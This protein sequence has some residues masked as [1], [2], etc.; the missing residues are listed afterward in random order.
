MKA[1]DIIPQAAIAALLTIFMLVLVEIYTMMSANQANADLNTLMLIM[2]GMVGFAFVAGGFAAAYL[3]ARNQKD[4]MDRAL[5]SSSM[6]GIIT[7]LV[8]GLL[9]TA[10]LVASGGDTGE[11]LLSLTLML[12]Q[13][14][15]VAVGASAIGGLLFT[16]ISGSGQSTV[17]AAIGQSL[18]AY[19]KAPTAIVPPIVFAALGGAFIAV[20]EL[21]PDYI[22]GENEA[23]AASLLLTLVAVAFISLAMAS[24]VLAVEKKRGLLGLFSAS[25]S[26][27]LKAFASMI[28]VI[29][30]P[31][32]LVTIAVWATLASDAVAAWVPYLLPFAGLAAVIY[33]V[34]FTFAPFS[35]VADKASALASMKKSLAFVRAKPMAVLAMGG[36]I[37]LL[38]LAIDLA[39]IVIDFAAFTVGLDSTTATAVVSPILNMVV[40]SSCMA[41]FYMGGKK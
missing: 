12:V 23:L 24:I 20:M 13:L 6:E 11:A 7:V 33:F 29:A 4:T 38:T 10:W 16:L 17:S 1:K 31:A 28:A 19:T 2:M 3:A 37:V 34:A 14:G 8:V 22:A 9:Y 26:A 35:A 32:A 5:A 27:G 39:L 40:V 25:L 36:A 15:M 41:A 18:K 21:V 30:P